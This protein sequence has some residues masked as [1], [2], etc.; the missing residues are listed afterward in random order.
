MIVLN[1]KLIINVKECN[2]SH[3]WVD[4]RNFFKDVTAKHEFDFRVKT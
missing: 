1:T 4:V 2:T 3:K